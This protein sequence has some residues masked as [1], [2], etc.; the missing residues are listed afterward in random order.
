MSFS[1]YL[2][3]VEHENDYF[4]LHKNETVAGTH[5]RMNGFA[6]RLVQTQRKKATWKCPIEHVSFNTLIPL[7]RNDQ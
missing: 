3:P 4:D 1:S 7:E 2:V 6:S 5:F